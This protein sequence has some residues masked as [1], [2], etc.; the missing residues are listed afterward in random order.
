M[1]T[2]VVEHGEETWTRYQSYMYILNNQKGM[3]ELLKYIGRTKR[4]KNTFGEVDPTTY[5]WS[6]DNKY[7][8]LFQNSPRK[9]E[10][11]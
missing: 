5:T 8:Y 3:V 7:R 11:P 2:Q 10:D 4:Y 6:T 9:K 1:E